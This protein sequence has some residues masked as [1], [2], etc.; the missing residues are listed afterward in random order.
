V[1]WFWFG[2]AGD[3]KLAG[4]ACVAGEEEVAAF[5]LSLPATRQQVIRFSFFF[6]YLFN[7]HFLFKSKLSD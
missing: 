2:N 4:N 5:S 6:I 3:R 7:F 1:I